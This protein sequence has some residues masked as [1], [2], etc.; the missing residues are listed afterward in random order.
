MKHEQAL[1]E[2]W[3]VVIALCYLTHREWSHGR[4]AKLFNQYSW[5]YP[6][7]INRSVAIKV[8]LASLLDLKFKWS[9]NLKMN[10][11]RK[12]LCESLLKFF[13]SFF[14][15]R[16][17]IFNRLFYFELLVCPFA[18]SSLGVFGEKQLSGLAE[19]NTLLTM[20]LGAGSHCRAPTCALKVL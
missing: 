4:R 13:H 17:M 1:P 10:I 5:L 11:R 6:E 20:K 16:K 7:F 8:R 9:V 12:N 18:Q 19:T 14:L 15:L 3:R 2:R